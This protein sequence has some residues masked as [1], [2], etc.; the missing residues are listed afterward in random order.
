MF[1][2]GEVYGEGN[3]IPFREEDSGSLD[4]ASLRACYPAAK[5]TAETLCIAYAAQF[6]IE[7]V[8]STSLPYL[9][10]FLHF[11]R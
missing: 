2:P 11:K 5:R 8:Y 6:Q 10:T 7:T 3:G 4:W 9:W 1:L